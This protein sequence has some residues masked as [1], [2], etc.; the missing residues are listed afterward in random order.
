M[1]AIK[2][3]FKSK[4]GLFKLVEQIMYKRE[5]QHSIYKI[6][7]KFKINFDEQPVISNANGFSFQTGGPRKR[8]KKES[9]DSL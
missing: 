8:I 4:I 6:V 5:Q 2:S 1:N 7:D 3:T 9:E